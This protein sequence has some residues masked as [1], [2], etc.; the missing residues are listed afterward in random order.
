[1]SKAWICSNN[2]GTTEI[3]FA[4]T[5]RRAKSYLKNFTDSFEDYRCNDI[6]PERAKVLDYLGHN[7]GYVMNWHNDEDRIALVKHIYSGCLPDIKDE[8]KSCCAKELCNKY[9][10]GNNGQENT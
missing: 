3:V 7:D 8:C 5:K 2:Y 9:K 1:M 10:E 4:D 6:Y